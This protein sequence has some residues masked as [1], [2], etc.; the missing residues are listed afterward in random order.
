MTADDF[1]KK[2]SESKT[3]KKLTKLENFLKGDDGETEA[4][5][6]KFGIVF[7]TA[8]AFVKMP[9][10]EIAILNITTTLSFH[11]CFKF[12]LVSFTKFFVI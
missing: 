12:Y 10:K 6:V 9:L 3:E 11:R 1:I 8:K 5:G 7:K 4:L 2:L